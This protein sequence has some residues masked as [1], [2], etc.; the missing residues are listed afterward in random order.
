MVRLRQ[1]LLLLATTQARAIVGGDGDPAGETP[2]HAAGE[3][4]RYH[5][6]AHHK[7]GTALSSAL[8]LNMR[9][10]LNP[11]LEQKI[12]HHQVKFMQTYPKT[13]TWNA[14]WAV[15]PKL[16]EAL[17]VTYEDMRVPSL[18]VIMER[19]PNR[20]VHMIRNAQSQIVSN[21]VYT[22]H[23]APGDDLPYDVKLGRLL[24]KRSL[25]W[26]LERMCAKQFKEYYPQMIA[27]H[28]YLNE[29]KPE[30]ILE[31]QYED[32]ETDFNGTVRRILT[33]YLGQGHEAIERIVGRASAS[34]PDNWAKDRR[35][36]NHHISSRA[37]KEHVRQYLLNITESSD[38]TSCFKRISGVSLAL[39][40]DADGNIIPP[41]VRAMMS[42]EAQQEWRGQE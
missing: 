25:R 37:E 41:Q 13:T 14:T 19:C 7:A 24:R 29:H 23:L 31:I 1:L 12:K 3:A 15:C 39:G 32:F 10:V 6:Y 17:A 27:M 8:F 11:R 9:A 33:H 30:S 26:G 40:Y 18:E 36:R 16:G 5:F 4:H 28:K 34:N 38:E 20:A 2:Q 21:Y 22:K 35:H 42:K